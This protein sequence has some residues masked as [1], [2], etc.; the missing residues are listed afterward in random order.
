MEGGSGMG[1]LVPY[2]KDDR[3]DAAGEAAPMI[4]PLSAHVLHIAA[5]LGALHTVALSSSHSGPSHNRISVVK[6][7]RTRNR[8]PL[9]IRLGWGERVL[10]LD[11]AATDC[12]DG[13]VAF[14]GESHRRV[15]RN[16]G[17]CAR[18]P[19]IASVGRTAG[20]SFR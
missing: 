13:H 7:L 3:V 4:A 10:W 16:L 9:Y 14:E 1:D 8:R 19:R 11:R 15:G 12:N 20:R 17:S 6:S 5:A 2:S 18:S